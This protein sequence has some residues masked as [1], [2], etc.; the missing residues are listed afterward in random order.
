MLTSISDITGV[1]RESFTYS[2]NG[3][4]LSTQKALGASSFSVA[5]TRE[6][7]YLRSAV[8][9]STEDG[10][11]ISTGG[12]WQLPV[13]VVLTSP[14]ASSSGVEVASFAG[15]PRI[16]AR[17]QPAGSG[18]SAS[19]SSQGYDANGNVES[20]DDFNGTRVCY[21]N[22]LSRNLETVRVEGLVGGAACSVTGVGVA[23]PVGS[24]KVSTEWHPDW[25]LKTKVAEPGRITTSVY[26]GQPDPLN[27]GAVASCAPS[28][29]VLPD[30]KP[31]VVL[32][33]QVEQA[34]TDVNGSQGFSAALQAG[35][36]ARVRNWTYNEY[37]Q[38]LTE[39]DPL[40][41]TTRYEYYTDTSFT[42]AD[43]NAVGYTRGDLKLV[44]NAAGQQTK[45]NKYNK[46]GAVLEMEDP[47]GVITSYTYDARQRLTSTS[48]GGQT[49]TQE[50]WPT[51]LL[52]KVTQPD[53]QTYVQY[54]YD[55]AHRL[56]SVQDNLGNSITYTLDN[57]GNRT[58]EEVKDPG[59][60]LRRQLTRSIDALGRV[61]QITGR[62]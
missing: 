17:T 59:N 15:A 12:V 53:G 9:T 29:A 47:N 54:N 39:K 58:G 26:N 49:T 23:L 46:M 21:A 43:P 36:V 14:I 42:G 40:N 32:C 31:I 5:F 22:D 1:V 34:T 41:N 35:V 44:T 27:G 24:R 7:K 30:G 51:G 48:V 25:S 50:Y 11:V 19:S 4:A 2:P 20:R 52:K 6:P 60:A 8:E 18:C 57:L 33:K 61:Q 28:T 3:I 13:G 38:V 45:Y 16:V 10:E 62:Q 55:D 37:G 56:R